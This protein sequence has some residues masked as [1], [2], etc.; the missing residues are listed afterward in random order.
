MNQ[1]AEIS[2]HR[3]IDA[4]QLWKSLVKDGCTWEG[5]VFSRNWSECLIVPAGL[6]SQVCQTLSAYKTKEQDPENYHY[7]VE[8]HPSGEI[9]AVWIY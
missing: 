2:L 3:E 4:L 9:L 5:D 8:L 7:M 6:D 1:I